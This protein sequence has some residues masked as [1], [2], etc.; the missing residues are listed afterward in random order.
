MSS[1]TNRTGPACH[2]GHHQQPTPAWSPAWHPHVALSTA[3]QALVIGY[4]MDEVDVRTAIA[5]EDV[6]VAS[7]GVAVPAAG[8]L[9]GLTLTLAAGAPSRGSSATTC[10]GKACSTSRPRCGE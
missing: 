1:P 3:A 2:R 5:A 7:D 6:M 8:P 9:S 10:A 4:A